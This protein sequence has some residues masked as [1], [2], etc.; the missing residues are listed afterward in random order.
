[1]STSD[2]NTNNLNWKV[3]ASN[4]QTNVGQNLTLDA[5]GNSSL[6]LRTNGKTRLTIDG[7]GSNDGTIILNSSSNIL[8]KS[9]SIKTLNTALSNTGASLI[10]NS[11]TNS[12]S[13]Q[14]LLVAGDQNTT[15]AFSQSTLTDSNAL[16]RLYND[17]GAGNSYSAGFSAL[18]TTSRPDPLMRPST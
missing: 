14:V 18:S 11:G 6:L 15:S 7:T 2:F 10:F 5:S 17:G 12:S 8:N 4:I 9:L 13:A 3:Y 16:M 1:M